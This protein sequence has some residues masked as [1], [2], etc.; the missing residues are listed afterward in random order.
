MYR[1]LSSVGV[2]SA[3]TVFSRVQ[4][5]ISVTLFNRLFDEF[6]VFNRIIPCQSRIR[7]LVLHQEEIADQL[8]RELGHTKLDL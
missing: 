5:V 4:N 8:I 6:H 1:I 7:L 2:S 3:A